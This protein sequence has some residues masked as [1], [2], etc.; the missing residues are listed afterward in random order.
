MSAT[1]LQLSTIEATP[2]SEPVSQSGSHQILIT[3]VVTSI[4]L[5]NAIGLL[6]VLGRFAG[7]LSDGLPRGA[8]LLAALVTTASVAATRIVWRRTFPLGDTVLNSQTNLAHDWDAIV[9][10]GSSLALILMAVGFCYPGNH[11]SDWLI[12]FPA[13]VADQFWRQTFFDAGHPAQSLAIA[14]VELVAEFDSEFDEELAVTLAFSAEHEPIEHE[15]IDQNIEAALLKSISK[16]NR[17]DNAEQIVQQL[18]RV[19]DEQGQE[20]VYGTVRADFEAGQRTA[21]VH[22][23]FCPPLSRIPEIEAESFPG[24]PSRIKIVQAL[25]HGTR[26]DVRLPAPAENDRHIWIDLAEIGRASCRARV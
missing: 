13:L 1:P 14:P 20:I 12:W 2:Q 16:Q 4:A 3:A 5:L 8:M 24:T 6:I 15:S 26:M 25:A 23:G 17:S 9:G 11:T 7:A 19:R 18:Y 22:V 10:W 21:V